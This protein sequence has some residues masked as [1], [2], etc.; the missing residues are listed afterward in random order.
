MNKQVIMSAPN[1]TEADEGAMSVAR[2]L[3]MW[4]HPAGSKKRTNSCVEQDTEP[5]RTGPHQSRTDPS[6]YKLLSSDAMI[7]AARP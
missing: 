2:F 6:T 7:P 4:K 1:R 5:A 3:H